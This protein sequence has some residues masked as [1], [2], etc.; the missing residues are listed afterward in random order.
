MDASKLVPLASGLFL[1]MAVILGVLAF[2]LGARGAV[3][4]LAGIVIGLCVLA[5]VLL[6]LTSAYVVLQERKVRRE[7]HV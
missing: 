3:L 5:D 2:A 4:V 7:Q 1:A 6:L